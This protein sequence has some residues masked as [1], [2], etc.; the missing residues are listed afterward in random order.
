MEKRFMKVTIEFETTGPQVATQADQDNLLECNVHEELPHFI[1]KGETFYWLYFNDQGSC[2]SVCGECFKRVCL[3]EKEILLTAASSIMSDLNMLSLG[4]PEKT[5]AQKI[6][7]GNIVHQ[8]EMV[9]AV[10]HREQH[11]SG[12]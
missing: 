12:R 2:E 9:R 11:E 5:D 4:I 7:Y 6:A 1:Q 8:L 3:N 10:A